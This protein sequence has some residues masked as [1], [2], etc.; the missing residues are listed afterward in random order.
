[1]NETL[2]GHFIYDEYSFFNIKLFPCINTTENNNHC[3][4]PEIIDYY[5]KG[6][7][8]TMKFQDVELNP[9]NY[10]YPVRPRIQDLN[11]IVGTKIFQELHIFY[12][13]VNVET[14]EDFI[15]LIPKYSK[16]QYLKYHS[17][18]QMYNLIENDIYQT[19]EPFCDITIKL[20]DQLRIQRRSFKNIIEILT[21][22]FIFMKFIFIIVN[23]ILF[24]FINYLY[25]LQIV[26][27]LFK[28]DIRL[29][30]IIVKKLPKST[31]KMPNNI[32][33]ININNE[34]N[35]SYNVNNNIHY[36]NNSYNVND[37]IHSNTYYIDSN[38]NFNDR[39]DNNN[40]SVNNN[41]DRNRNRRILENLNIID[42]IKFNPFFIYCPFL[43]IKNK[44]FYLMSM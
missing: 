22:I 38:N 41:Y 19:R 34:N 43:C 1:M 42:K 26:N 13:I 39:N 24:H 4:F 27:K 21:K 23:S 8:L 20:H 5:L 12:Q 32:K 16:R 7:F 3:F 44:T 40:L 15:G 10:S 9:Q 25:E 37:N 14:N 31:I 11:F 6:A 30:L 33:N 35:N 29:K 28:F 17:Y 18:H 36:N 2:F